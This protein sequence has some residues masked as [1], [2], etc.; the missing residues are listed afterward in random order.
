[1]NDPEAIAKLQAA[2]AGNDAELYRQFSAL[3]TKLSRGCHL[4]GMLKFRTEAALPVP[5]D[6]VEPAAAIV[7]RFVTG[8][9]SYGSISLEA[10]T[11]LA[12]AMNTI[13]GKSNSGEGGENPRRL[14]P[15]PDGS[16]NPFR[17]AIKQVGARLCTH[18]PPAG[19]AAAHAIAA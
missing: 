14:E 5:I 17:S 9:M 1:M 19:R 10:H 12:L 11:T 4:R 2:T 3:N 7:K 16:K 18:A 13:G 8:A 6:E 15:L